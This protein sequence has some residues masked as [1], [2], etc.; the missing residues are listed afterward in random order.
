MSAESEYV[1]AV[2]NYHR[3]LDKYFRITRVIGGGS[4]I[5]GEPLTSLARQELREAY[6]KIGEAKQN[7]SL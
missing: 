4:Q 7:L 2:E 6:N 1:E 5:A 3:L